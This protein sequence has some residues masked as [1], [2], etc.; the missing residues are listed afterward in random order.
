M[1]ISELWNRCS[2]ALSQLAFENV[3]AQPSAHFSVGL[4]RN[5][6]KVPKFLLHFQ[7]YGT[8]A[9]ENIIYQQVGRKFVA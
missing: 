6:I 9:E 7:V 3:L 5:K 4:L 2:R 8:L 1:E